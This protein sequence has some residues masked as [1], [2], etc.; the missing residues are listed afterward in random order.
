MS[1]FGNALRAEP[2]PPDASCRSPARRGIIAPCRDC[3]ASWPSP[4]G[5]RSRVR[6]AVQP[7]RRRNANCRAQCR[8]L[9][10]RCS[11]PSACD[12]QQ[13]EAMPEFVSAPLPIAISARLSASWLQP[14]TFGRNRVATR[15][16]APR[17]ST[18]CASLQSLSYA[19]AIPRV[20]DREPRPPACP[21]DAIADGKPYCSLRLRPRSLRII[22]S[23]NLV[24]FD[25]CSI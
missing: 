2:P 15:L 20:V 13:R 17:R 18:A 19:R 4:A 14:L 7:S 22:R 1:R 24:L 25:A 21:H 16:A 12:F 6:I 3:S 9:S 5:T 8:R 11:L 23:V 10:C